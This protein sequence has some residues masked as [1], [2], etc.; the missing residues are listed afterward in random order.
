MFKN[1]S[2]LVTLATTLSLL[3]VL[4]FGLFVICFKYVFFITV[5]RT[6]KIEIEVL[7]AHFDKVVVIFGLYVFNAFEADRRRE[8]PHLKWLHKP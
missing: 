3:C 2:I 6:R 7:N 8:K 4:F 5:A 1:R